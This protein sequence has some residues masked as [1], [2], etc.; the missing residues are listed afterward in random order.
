MGQNYINISICVCVC[1]RVC[2]CGGGERERERELLGKIHFTNCL[3]WN[4]SFLLI[5]KSTFCS[6]LDHVNSYFKI[7]S[8]RHSKN[9][10]QAAMK[11][12]PLSQEMNTY[13]YIC[14]YTYIYIYRYIHIY[15]ILYTN[16]Y[17]YVMTK[18]DSGLKAVRE[19]KFMK[20]SHA[21]W[22]ITNIGKIKDVWII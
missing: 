6:H 14:V 13:T 8:N 1:A 5:K 22:K 21:I 20:S 15:N 4:I 9:A 17:T 19:Q 2:V 10:A 18:K 3:H 16:D 11:L 12:K 7:I